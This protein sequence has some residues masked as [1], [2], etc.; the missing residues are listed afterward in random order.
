MVAAIHAAI[1]DYERCVVASIG[2]DYCGGEFIELQMTHR[3]FEGAVM[4]RAD[5]C[6]GIE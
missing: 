6:R 2:G 3:E 4:E 1:R 5:K